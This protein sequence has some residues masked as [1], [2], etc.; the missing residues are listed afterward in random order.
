MNFPGDT[1]ATKVNLFGSDGKSFV[2]RPANAEFD[3]RYTKKTVKH[4]GGSIMLWGCF[5]VSGV[6]P[7]VWILGKMNAADYIDILQNKMLPFAED[8]MPLKWEFM[9]SPQK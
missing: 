1:C 4:G 9:G 5:S 6:G 7:I 3:P 2:R 8:E